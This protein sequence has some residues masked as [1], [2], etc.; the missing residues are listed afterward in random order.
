MRRVLPLL[1]PLA[2]S[3]ALAAALQ[4]GLL[5]ALHAEPVQLPA[6]TSHAIVTIL[7]SGDRQ[8]ECETISD[9]VAA[10]QLEL[11][12]EDLPTV[13]AQMCQVAGR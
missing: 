3:T 8:V 9:R 2:I 11:N 12:P 4:V 7:S 5:R 13:T 1:V 10:D 6:L